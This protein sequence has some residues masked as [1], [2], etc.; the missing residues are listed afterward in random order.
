M[1]TWALE[2]KALEEELVDRCI[3]GSVIF[4]I[5]SGK[6]IMVHSGLEGLKGREV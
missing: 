4:L 2:V 5:C 1:L 6:A 3:E